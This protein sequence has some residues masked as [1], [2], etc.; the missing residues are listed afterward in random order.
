MIALDADVGRRGVVDV[1]ITRL[2]F[3]PERHLLLGDS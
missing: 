2:V 1:Y 3:H